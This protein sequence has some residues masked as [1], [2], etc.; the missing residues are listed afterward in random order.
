MRPH[1]VIRGAL[2]LA[3]LAVPSALVPLACS[4]SSSVPP[5]T[6]A[7]GEASSTCPSDLPAACP[8]PAPGYD[9]S[10]GPLLAGRCGGCHGDGGI[11]VNQHDLR[12][13]DAVYR[14][15][16]SVLTQVYGCLMP[17]ADAAP[18]TPGERAALLGWLVCGA[19]N[20]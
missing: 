19:P 6:D 4:P 15:R 10:V 1:A 11:E 12:T 13:Y 17:P 2:A 9:A 16:S 20:N 8:S 14:Q 5:A 7:A 18:L 3:F